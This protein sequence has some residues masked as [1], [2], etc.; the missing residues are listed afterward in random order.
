MLTGKYYTGFL[1]VCQ[2]LCGSS[3]VPRVSGA[4][5]GIWAR[6]WG[7]RAKFIFMVPVTFLGFW[8]D[9]CSR[10]GSG[11]HTLSATM[12]AERPQNF[13]QGHERRGGEPGSPPLPY[14]ICIR[15]PHRQK[16]Q[17]HVF[18][19]SLELFEEEAFVDLA[20]VAGLAQVVLFEGACAAGRVSAPAGDCFQ[21]G[22]SRG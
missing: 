12:S 7:A 14:E 15:N 11:G 17:A 18:L 4:E 5:R 19:E 9:Y 6:F 21:V 20:G 10:E 2:I 3:C 1:S 13:S 22:A 16:R 8:G